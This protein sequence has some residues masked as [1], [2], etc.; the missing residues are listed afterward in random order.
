MSESVLR[1]PAYGL[2]GYAGARPSIG[3]KRLS[4]AAGL[5]V[6]G[7]AVAAGAVAAVGTP[8]EH[9]K[10]AGAGHDTFAPS[11]PP[12]P[13]PPPAAPAPGHVAPAQPPGMLAEGASGPAVVRLQHE[14]AISADGSF[15]PRTRAAV[16]AFQQSHGLASD[17]IVGPKTQSALAAPR[18]AAATHPSATHTSV[19]QPAASTNTAGAAA[20]MRWAF[21][22][23]GKPYVYGATGPSAFDCSGFTTYVFR[24]AHISLPRTSQ[25]QYQTGKPVSAGNIQAGDLLFWDTGGS[26]PSHVGIAISPTQAISAET[27]SGVGIHPIAQGYWGSHF[28]GARSEF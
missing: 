3:R 26:G 17:G 19:K 18:P 8:S 9:G 12:V 11:A 10:N 14:L 5:S 21:S 20:V 27:S 2:G 6:A 13:S 23:L 22:E 25:A 15:G 28:L 4:K 24:Q 16:V 1:A 7:I